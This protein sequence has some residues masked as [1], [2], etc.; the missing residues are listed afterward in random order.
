MPNSGVP[1]L[2]VRDFR[3]EVQGLP[4]TCSTSDRVA[5]L[6]SDVTCIGIV[7]FEDQFTATYHSIHT[8]YVWACVRQSL[9]SRTYREPGKRVIALLAAFDA[10]PDEI[11]DQHGIGVAI[12]THGIWRP[13]KFSS[14]VCGQIRANS[15]KSLS[16]LAALPALPSKSTGPAAILKPAKSNSKPWHRFLQ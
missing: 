8:M 12:A 15:K 3:G 10:K 4:K 16:P 11:V 7:P 5:S 9:M 14:P 6:A 2:A 1:F 13:N